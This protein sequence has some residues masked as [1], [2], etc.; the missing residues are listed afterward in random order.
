MKPSN[1]SL[2]FHVMGTCIFLFFLTFACPTPHAY[3]ESSPCCSSAWTNSPYEAPASFVP[4][5]RVLPGRRSTCQYDLAFS[6]DQSPNRC[7]SLSRPARTYAR[8][9]CLEPIT[10]CFLNCLYCQQKFQP[11]CHLK[12]LNGLAHPVSGWP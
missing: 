2:F 4:L 3:S 7:N 10:S 12:M 1:R 11:A 5:A 6:T 9:A 8:V